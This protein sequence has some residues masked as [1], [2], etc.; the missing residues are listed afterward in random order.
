MALDWA[1]GYSAGDRRWLSLSIVSSVAAGR[2]LRA[3]GYSWPS[4]RPGIAPRIH[5][6]AEV[7]H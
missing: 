7:C 4:R 6:D 3:M 1:M 5:L 2:P